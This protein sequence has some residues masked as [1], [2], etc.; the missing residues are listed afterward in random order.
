MDRLYVVTRSDLKPGAQLAQ[1]CHA[2]ASFAVAHPE[3]HRAWATGEANVVCLSAGDEL[4][5]ERLLEQAARAALP[6]AAFREP[7]LGGE[8]TAIALAGDAARLVST[9]PLALRRAA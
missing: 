9:L 4:E 6:S 2:V 8:L 3:A 1:S 5:L 7:D